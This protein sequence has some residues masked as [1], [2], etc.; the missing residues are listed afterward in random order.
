MKKSGHWKVG[1]LA[2]AVGL[3]AAGSLQAAEDPKLAAVKKL[4]RLAAVGRRIVSENQ[5]LINDATK[6]D[7]GFTAAAFSDKVVKGLMEEKIDLGKEIKKGGLTGKNLDML[8]QAMQEVITDAQ[9][10][11]NKKDM[12]FKG[13]LPALFARKS[14]ETFNQKGG[15][16]KGKLTALQVRNVKNSP[17]AWEK[18]N[19][20]KFVDPSYPTGKAISEVVGGEL[21]YIKPEYYTTAGKC[22]TCHGEP[23][24]ERDISGGLKEGFK[25]GQGGAA[26]SFIVKE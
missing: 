14:F 8:M 12:G 22:L 9:P 2:M 11:I 20:E 18:K 10:L 4:E 7:K 21:R 5:A 1:A 25:D 17:D 23:K 19:L 6:E 26:L 13:F 24:G 16:I 3:S 15:V